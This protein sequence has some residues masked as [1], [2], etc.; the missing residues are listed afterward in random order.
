MRTQHAIAQAM[1]RT[2]PHPARV[3]RQHRRDA[4][5]HLARRF[6]SERDRE[7]TVR[8]DLSGLNEPRNARGEHARLAAASAGENESR[9]LRQGYGCALLRIE[10]AE[11]ITGGHGQCADYTGSCCCVGLRT[12]I[13]RSTDRPRGQ[14]SA[15]R[16]SMRG[17]SMRF[18]AWP[19]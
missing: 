3:D 16:L 7:D 13:L 12:D 9:F 19:I 8:P 5:Q 6:V 15:S 2:Y 14:R 4:G 18:I 11:N 1:K 10:A 17:V